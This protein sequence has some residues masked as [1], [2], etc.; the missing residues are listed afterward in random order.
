MAQPDSGSLA[1]GL[2]PAQ[3][4]AFYKVRLTEVLTQ[5]NPAGLNTIGA[6][7]KQFPGNEHKVY[8]QICKKC[9]VTPVDPPKP[10]DFENGVPR[11][12]AAQNDGKVKQWLL[13]NAFDKYATQHQF[14]TMSW[15]E[16]IAIRTK[17]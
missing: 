11:P 12:A 3:V 17:G 14:V 7:L 15:D 5:H 2:T 6:L 4:F 8:V 1:S 16:F 9:G 10:S 13:K